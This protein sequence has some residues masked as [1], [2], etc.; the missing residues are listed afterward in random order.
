MSDR[1][2]RVR[3]RKCHSYSFL[4]VSLLLRTLCQ[5]RKHLDLSNGSRDIFSTIDGGENHIP[6]V[7]SPHG[8]VDEVF[9]KSLSDF[10]E[11]C[12]DM[13]GLARVGR[14]SMSSVFPRVSMG[15]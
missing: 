3:T 6:L 15:A 12:L 4:R 1:N 13:V 2:C 7:V 9:W 5:V 8:G 11:N 14:Y 10:H